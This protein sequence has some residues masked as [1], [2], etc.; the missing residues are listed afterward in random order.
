MS[1]TATLYRMVLP[2]HVCPYGELAMNMLIDHGY[3][4]DD[5]ILRTREEVEE[6]KAERDLDTTPLI[7]IDGEHIGGSGELK[8][9]LARNSDPMPL[10]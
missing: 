7:I 10:D 5:H 2:D 3:T 6:F 8:R 4:V 1:R 9:Y